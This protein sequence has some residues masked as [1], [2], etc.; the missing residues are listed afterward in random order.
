MSRRNPVF[1]M[2]LGLC[3]AL[4]VTTRVDNALGLGAVVVLVLALS[5]LTVSLL[6]KHVPENLRTPAYIVIIA[7]YVTV[8]DLFL[9]AYAP[10]LSKN[11]GIFL[12]LTAV[13]CLILG[14]ILIFAQDNPPGA[15]LVDAMKSGFSF[16]CA[17]VLIALV[18]EVLGAGTITLFAV[19]PFRGVLVIP[20]LSE[21][22]VRVFGLAAGAFL[23]AGYLKALY[24]RLVSDEET[25][26][27]ES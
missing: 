24:D 23:V 27:R 16:F 9:R 8:V 11:L 1:A 7:S 13:N 21:N 17:L 2:L 20:L 14:R 15:S 10:G 5:S 6:G 3:P 22:P 12:P 26:E 4:A 19:G 25:G 18:R